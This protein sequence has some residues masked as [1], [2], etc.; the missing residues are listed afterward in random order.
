MCNHKL[1]TSDYKAAAICIDC[2]NIK[3]ILYLFLPIFFEL[4]YPNI[5]H[6]SQHWIS[7]LKL[8]SSG[9]VGVFYD[10]TWVQI[11]LWKICQTLLQVHRK[12]SSTIRRKSWQ[13]HDQKLE[14]IMLHLLHI[15]INVW[16][17]VFSTYKSLLFPEK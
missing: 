7:L 3:R 6:W 1:L 17:H 11:E 12:P 14:S 13:L 2:S 5:A 4:L 8:D 15:E 16:S 10:H 9:I